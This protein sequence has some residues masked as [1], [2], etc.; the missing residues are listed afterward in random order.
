MPFASPTKPAVDMGASASLTADMATLAPDAATLVTTFNP[1]FPTFFDVLGFL[2]V[3]SAV[4]VASLSKLFRGTLLEDHNFWR[5]LCKTVA[6]SHQLYLRPEIHVNL[7]VSS[8][9]ENEYW[10]SCLR[11]LWQRRNMWV[12]PVDLPETGAAT[13]GEGTAGA[14]S[15]TAASSSTSN[16]GSTSNGFSINVCA[17][18]RPLVANAGGDNEATTVVLPLHQKIAMIRQKAKLDGSASGGAIS[19]KEAFSRLMSEMSE[20][21]VGM[22]VNAAKAGESVDIVVVEGQRGAESSTQTDS[23]G[24][25]EKPAGTSADFGVQ[26]GVLSVNAATSTV[27]TAAAGCGLRE[28]RFDAVMDDKSKQC[29]VYDVNAAPLLADFINGI[30]VTMLMFGQTGSGK[31]F[32]MFGG[33]FLAGLHSQSASLGIIP[34]VC[35]ELLEACAAREAELGITFQLAVSYVEVFGDEVYD[36]IKADEAGPAQIMIHNAAAAQRFVLE[37]YCDRPV[38]TLS[39]VQDVLKTGEE[40][41]RKAATAMN[42]H[43]S[44][45]HTLFILS[46]EQT[47]RT[48]DV[49]HKSKMFLA[50]LGGSEDLKKSKVNEGLAIATAKGE[51]DSDNRDGNNNDDTAAAEAAAELEMQLEMERVAAQKDRLKEA[52][53]I[54]YGLFALK[55]VIEALN[56]KKSHIPYHMSKLTL[57]LKDGLGGNSKTSVVV[58]AAPEPSNATES[59]QTLR[60]GEMC[61][62]VKTT[63]KQT[64]AAFARAI[65]LLDSKI[66]LCEEQIKKKEKWATRSR[67]VESVVYDF[68]DIRKDEDWNNT[69]EP[70]TKRV[71]KHKVEGQ[72]L[73]GA[74]EYREQLAGLLDSKRKLLNIG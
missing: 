60:F 5:L 15:A 6:T 16:D 68:E 56:K 8:G 62:T 32:T 72:V 4:C 35:T 2:D 19:K 9:D 74:E 20:K 57:M 42:E 28:F 18:F 40:R 30:N 51:K 50:D 36:L 63:T 17:R 13:E 33:Q 11:Y 67:W 65:K 59:I 24:I 37:G 64:G 3:G 1:C 49:V 71:V 21:G 26:T 29:D 31:T 48:G 39:E 44:R 41:K 7:A 54:N 34:R 22:G 61:Q 23:D 70:T 43:S 47:D 12:V 10:K 69:K 55:M 73:V 52:Q 14:E 53:N 45:A 25:P 27:L 66:A 46:L 58:C 38:G